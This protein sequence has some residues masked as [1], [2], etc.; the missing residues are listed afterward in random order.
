MH[1]PDSRIRR[2][3]TFSPARFCRRALLILALLVPLPALAQLAAEAMLLVATPKLRDAFFARTVVLVTRHDRAPP[4]G[5]ILNRQI[6]LRDTDHPDR[7][8]NFGGP[9]SPERFAYLF[10]GEPPPALKSQ[11]LKLPDAWHFGIASAAPDDLLKAPAVTGA[12]VFRGFSGWSPGQLEHEIARGDWLLL[13]FDASL[14]LREDGDALWRE[15][16]ARASSRS[17]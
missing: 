12:K 8:I 3:A 9:V 15:L 7:K 4:L 6:V 11:F 16:L 17:I 13:P 14:I 10:R 5:V 2:D 1:L